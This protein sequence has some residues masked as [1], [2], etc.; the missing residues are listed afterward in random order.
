M[1]K[2]MDEADGSAK[3][4]ILMIKSGMKVKL[5]KIFKNID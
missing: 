4:E 2:D 5:K 1:E 3:K